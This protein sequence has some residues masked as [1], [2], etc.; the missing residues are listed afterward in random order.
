[1]D[2]IDPITTL[3]DLLNTDMSSIS[4]TFPVLVA[5]LYEFE[6]ASFKA[7]ESKKTPGNKVLEMQLK[8]L[9]SAKTTAGETV[10]PGFPITHRVGLNATQATESKGEYDPRK[11]IAQLKEAVFGDKNAKVA[12][13]DFIGKKVLAQVKPEV[14]KTGEFGEQTRVVRFVPKK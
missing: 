8:L 2:T 12:D 4:T 9:T 5:G 13:S 1:M 10:N 3:N 14:D 11:N 7:V 6:I